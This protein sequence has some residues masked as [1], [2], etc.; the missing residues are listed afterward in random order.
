LPELAFVSLG[1]NIEPEKYL[2]LAVARLRDLGELITCSRVYQNPA[3]AP[4]SQPDY[5]NTA[6]LIET[7]LLPLEMRARLRE[8]E[9]QLD[10]V[11]TP[12]K[13]APRTIDLDLCLY[14]DLQFESPELLLPDPD[15]LER[16][17][18]AL[19]LA[20]LA[21]QHIYPGSSRTLIEIASD[22]QQGVDFTERP[23]LSLAKLLSDIMEIPDD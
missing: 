3:I 19:T 1:S 2:P 4:E 5:L 17:Y 11:R 22:L 12:D 23:E 16:P 18:L 20:E 21:P 8:I 9:T 6:V 7:H 10:R 13:F 14:G 15:I